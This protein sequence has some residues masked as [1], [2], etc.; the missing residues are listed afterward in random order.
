M[1]N[2]VFHHCGGDIFFRARTVISE[3]DYL[4]LTDLF[5]EESLAALH[6]MDRAAYDR[7]HAL[8]QQLVD[9]KYEQHRWRRATRVRSHGVAFLKGLS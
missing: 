1:A 7:A 4:A 2:L 6:A 9:A 5:G 8:H 3:D